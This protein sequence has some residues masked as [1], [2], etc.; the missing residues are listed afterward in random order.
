[1]DRKALLLRIT[2]FLVILNAL[3]WAIVGVAALVRSGRYTPPMDIYM[4]IIGLGS[5]AFGLLLAAAAIAL[6]VGSRKLY[7]LILGL[8]ILSVILPVFDDF[9]WADLIGLLPALA[10]AVF[11][12]VEKKT[13]TGPATAP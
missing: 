2:K 7:F 4:G 12:L 5:I 8:M 10:A 6:R 13:L 9:G 1:M 11:M 3:A